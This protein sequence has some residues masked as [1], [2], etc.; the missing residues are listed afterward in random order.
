MVEGGVVGGGEERRA[1]G[2][3]G[4]VGALERGVRP[5]GQRVV[6]TLLLGER[7]DEA[8]NR[9]VRFPRQSHGVALPRERARLGRP[10]QPPRD[11]HVQDLLDAPQVVLRRAPRRRGLPPAHQRRGALTGPPP[12]P[13]A[14][15]QNCVHE[16]PPFV[17]SVRLWLHA[18]T[19]PMPR[20]LSASLSC[21]GLVRATYPCA[22]LPAQDAR[23]DSAA[24]AAL[25]RPCRPHCPARG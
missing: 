10:R 4:R 9:P 20:V 21:V 2:Q 1:G 19:Y 8:Q 15:P 13:W 14:A 5:P 25:P 7:R 24:G 16:R 17:L 18:S 11:R 6:G 22:G 12:A 23:G 3:L